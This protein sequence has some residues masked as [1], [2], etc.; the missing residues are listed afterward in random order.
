[1]FCANRMVC[2]D[3][4]NNYLE[5]H[6]CIYMEMIFPSLSEEQNRGYNTNICKVIICYCGHL[7]QAI[8]QET[9]RPT[10]WCTC[11]LTPGK[12]ETGRFLQV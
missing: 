7:S 3:I 10:V 9:V 2:L 12:L 11:N 4:S 6:T 1:M 8:V 5:I